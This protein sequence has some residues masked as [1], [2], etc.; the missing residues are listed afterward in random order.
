[1]VGATWVFHS[2]CGCIGLNLESGTFSGITEDFSYFCLNIR[3]IP[4]THVLG[5]GHCRQ[6]PDDCHH[7]HQLNKGEALA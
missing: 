6:N 4:E 1:L 3:A 5:N 7:D 2:C